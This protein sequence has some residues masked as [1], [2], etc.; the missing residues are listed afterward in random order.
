MI[1]ER[2]EHMKLVA[3][4]IEREVESLFDEAVV[5]KEGKDAHVREKLELR[6][7]EILR[8]FDSDS[9]QKLLETCD[10]LILADGVEHPAEKQFRAGAFAIDVTPLELPV[11]VNGGMTERVVDKVEVAPGER[12]GAGE[13]I[14]TVVDVG[15]LRI[16]ASVLEHDLPLL[17]VGGDASVL[18]PA[19]GGSV[20]G[21][22]AAILPLVDS[23]TRAGR[24]IVNVPPRAA[25]ALRPGMYA[26]VRLEATRLP[27]RVIVPA[28]AVIQRDGRPLVFVVRDGRAQWVYILPGRSNG[29]ETEVLPDSSTGQI[30]LKAGDVVL[31]EGHLTLTHDAPVRVTAKAERKTN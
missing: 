22:I 19:V 9:R 27:G 13:S 4:D 10:E 1:A 21:N 3:A 11:I 5:K 2:T 31:I 29:A 7:F 14:A 20:H 17:R 8:S 26:D 12:V 30:P 24:A 28:P 25:A 6:C 15:D 18:T 23:T 16:E